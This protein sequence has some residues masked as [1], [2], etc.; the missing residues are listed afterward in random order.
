MSATRDVARM[1]TL[2]PWLLQRPGAAIAEAADAF[3][4]GERQIRADLG[5]LDF[6]GLPG[7]GGGDL[8][9]VTVIGDR[10]LVEMADEL[11]RPLRPTPSEAL[12]LVLA[13]DAVADALGPELPALASA[14]GKIREAL[15]VP[16][17]VADVLEPDTIEL[18][19]RL[20]EAL[21]AKRRVRITYQGRADSELR[22]RDVDPWTLHVVDGRWYLDGHDHDA[23]DRRIFRF[24]R[25]SR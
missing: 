8:F 19:D 2:I 23:A 7:L 25:S 3:G 21:A 6:C 5:H 11:R 12:R 16:E 14:V 9:D 22:E 20:R 13:V 10:V 4:V 24:T 18:A 1:L 17:R 15:G